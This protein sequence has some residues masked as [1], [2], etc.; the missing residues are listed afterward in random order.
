[1]IEKNSLV[2]FF[3]FTNALT[4]RTQCCHYRRFDARF[5]I[6]ESNFALQFV[7]KNL[8][9]RSTKDVGLTFLIQNNQK[10]RKKKNSIWRFECRFGYVTL[11][12]AYF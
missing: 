10:I 12:Q 11:L 8:A 7:E 6:I 3:F 9:Y 1:M 5:G 2:L 4:F